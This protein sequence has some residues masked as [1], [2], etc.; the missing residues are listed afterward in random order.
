VFVA[1]LG[2]WPALGISH[3]KVGD[4][5]LHVWNC[6][7]ATCH[8]HV[9]VGRALQDMRT[10]SCVPDMMIPAMGFPLKAAPA[11]SFSTACERVWVTV[12]PIN[13][14]KSPTVRNGERDFTTRIHVL[15]RVLPTKRDGRSKVNTIA[16]CLDLDESGR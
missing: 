3:Y 2:N 12:A 10:S 6:R 9:V 5:L 7:S 1:Y 14:W 4:F 8:A 15:E 11:N 13:I 16:Q